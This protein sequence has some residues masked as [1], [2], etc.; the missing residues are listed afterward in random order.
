MRLSALV[1]FQI[2]I[3]T[4]SAQL[5]AARFGLALAPHNHPQQPL[6]APEQQQQGSDPKQPQPQVQ[7]PGVMLSDVM[8]RDRSTNAFAG[9]ARDSEAV[10]RR[11]DDAARN[12]TVLAPLNSAVD[13]LPRKPWEDPAEYRAL[14][15]GAYEGDD[16]RGRARRNLRRF[17]EAHVVPVS[18]WPEGE[19]TRTLLEGD[20]DVW[21]ETRDGVRVIQPDNIEV[22]SIASRVGNGEVWILKGVRNYA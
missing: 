8:G 17:V 10:A 16:G 12:S 15:A 7:Q 14:G 20:R 9:F 11:L 21:W 13:G 1:Y 6:M 18:P 19:K 3:A 2:L 22:A 5:V 4:A